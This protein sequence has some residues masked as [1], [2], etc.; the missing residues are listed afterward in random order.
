M[1]IQSGRHN[2]VI[3][4][5][6][7]D[8]EL[9]LRQLRDRLRL[10]HPHWAA[11]P[12]GVGVILGDFNVCDPEGRFNVWNQTV[13][14]GDPRKIAVFHS[15]FHTSLRLLNLI[16]RAGSPQSLGSHVLFQ[17]LIV[18]NQSRDFQCCSHAFE[19]L[20][21]RIIPSAHAAV[22]FVIQKPANRE[23]TYSQLGVQK[24]R[25]FVLCC[26]SFTTITGSFMTGFVH[27]QSLRFFSRRR[28]R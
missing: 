21:K 17:G 19:N 12:Y 18:F 3:V 15:F 2:L 11:Y 16:P 7:F 20:E 13:T 10:I 23:Q 9:T 14:D 22:P 27:L 5:L 26:S 6:H 4:D 28:R 1:N 8:L 24:S 25:F